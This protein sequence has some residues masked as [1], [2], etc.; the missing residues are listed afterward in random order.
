[1]TPARTRFISLLRND[2]LQLAAGDLDFG[3]YRVLNH[4]RAEID[5]FLD[6]ALPAHIARQPGALPGAADA[7]AARASLTLEPSD[8][9]AA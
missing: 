6:E 3:I 2:I 7:S 8:L 4:R 9:T 1:M 5:H